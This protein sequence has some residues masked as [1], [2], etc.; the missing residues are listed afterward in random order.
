MSQFNGD[1]EPVVYKYRI[2][3]LL[4]VEMYLRPY[5]VHLWAIN[6]DLVDK[7]VEIWPYRR[8]VC[9]QIRPLVNGFRAIEHHALIPRA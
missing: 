3:S 1:G 9:M 8:H 5:F 4:T 7:K 6:Y 2:Y